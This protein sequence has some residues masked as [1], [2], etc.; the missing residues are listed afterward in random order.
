[1]KKSI[2]GFVVAA[3][4]TFIMSGCTMTKMGVAYMGMEPETQDVYAKMMD[5]ISEYGDPARAMMI[6]RKIAD[7][8]TNEDAVDAIKAVTEERNMLVTGDVKMYSKED[9]APDEVAHARIISVCNLST[10]KIFLNHS[11]Y[12]GGFMPCRIMLVEYGNGDRFLLTMDLTMAIY[13]GDPLPP[14]ML[15]QA[16]VVKETMEM[17]ITRGAQGDF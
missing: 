6:E 3:A 8:V 1:M 17:L 14:E 5:N 13:G 15:K 10:A 16:N 12:Y 4:A 9:A 11:R 7:D 2:F